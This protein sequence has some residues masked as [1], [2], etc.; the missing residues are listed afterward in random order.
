MNTVE[1]GVANFRAFQI[2]GNTFFDRSEARM[3]AE[4]EAQKRADKKKWSRS[5]KIAFLAIVIVVLMPPATWFTVQAKGMIE[6]LIQITNWFEAHK[7]QFQKNSSLSDP[8]PGVNSNQ[9]GGGS[10]PSQ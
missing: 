7:A 9:V 8:N 2:R 10:W 1:E 5:N 4:E 6:D 3:D